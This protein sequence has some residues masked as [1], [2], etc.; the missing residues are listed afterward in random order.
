[1]QLSWP[2]SQ[3]EGAAPA[4]GVTNRLAG[5]VLNFSGENDQRSG[6]FSKGKV[7]CP[8]TGRPGTDSSYYKPDLVI[9]DRT[10]TVADIHFQN[11]PKAQKSS[12][13]K[14]FTLEQRRRWVRIP[15]R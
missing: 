7:A 5:F 12:N 2:W 13:C 15:P 14:S 9:C 3:I 6:A 11:R 1:M 10:A 8:H 4:T